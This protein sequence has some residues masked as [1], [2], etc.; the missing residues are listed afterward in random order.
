MLVLS[1]YLLLFQV[2]TKH[3]SHS[4]QQFP[5]SP[6]LHIPEIFGAIHNCI[7]IRMWFYNQYFI[8]HQRILPNTTSTGTKTR[9]P[10]WTLFILIY[11][12]INL[13]I[14]SNI[15][16]NDA[17]LSFLGFIPTIII[18][19]GTSFHLSHHIPTY[20][21]YLGNFHTTKIQLPT[22]L[23]SN[24][25][26]LAYLSAWHS[27]HQRHP[28]RLLNFTPGGC[29]ICIDTGASCCISNNRE[30][31]LDLTPSPSSVLT[32]IASSLVIAGK[33]TIC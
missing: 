5:L 7:S 2:I 19:G 26:K 32:G 29:P 15:Y 22:R 14:I 30:D 16:N 28:P 20:T 24:S 23:Q 1:P 31:F 33:G 11:I 27:L 13:L 4:I 18:S 17:P 3:P 12:F 25:S 21:N 6:L 9:L 8:I 10:H